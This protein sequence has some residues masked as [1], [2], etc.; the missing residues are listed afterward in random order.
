[1]NQF[2][3]DGAEEQ[4]RGKAQKVGGRI[5]EAAGNLTGREDWEAEGEADQVEGDL[6]DDAGRVTRKVGDAAEDIGDAF[7]GKK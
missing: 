7:K 2:Q 3:K 6:R 5:E 4:A 1:M